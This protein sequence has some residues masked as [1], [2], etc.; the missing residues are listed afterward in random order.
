MPDKWREKKGLESSSEKMLHVLNVD[1]LLLDQRD[2]EQPQGEGETERGKL[3]STATR[4]TAQ[5][6]LGWTKDERGTWGFRQGSQ[7]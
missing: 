6:R 3:T 4:L 5:L 7:G 2:W 1:D